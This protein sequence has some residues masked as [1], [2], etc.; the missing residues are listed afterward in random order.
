MNKICILCGKLHSHDEFYKDNRAKDGLRSECISCFK[1]RRK[2]YINNKRKHLSNLYINNNFLSEDKECIICK[3]IKK[4]KDFPKSLQHKDGHG[5]YCKLCCCLISKKKRNSNTSEWREKHREQQKIWRKNNKI[6][7][8]KSKK[9]WKIN[10]RKR[11]PIFRLKESL[12]ARLRL[13]LHGK[14]KSK[15]TL[16]LLGCSMDDFKNHLQSKFY[17]NM[18]WDNY[19]SYWH[20]DHIIPCSKFD[21]TKES[22][23]KKCFHYSNLQPLTA[24]DN[25]KKGSKL[26][27]NNIVT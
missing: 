19:G 23:Q 15:S 6:K 5:P 22:E 2:K 27:Y 17:T 14:T 25:L 11:D 20:I 18:S 3:N 4:R 8:S 7:V 21:L 24:E 26:I 16:E 9:K 1:K 12:Y 10:R 13:A